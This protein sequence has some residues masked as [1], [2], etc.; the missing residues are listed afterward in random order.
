[1]LALVASM[2]AGAQAGE[3]DEKVRR[4]TLDECLLYRGP[5]DGVWLGK[6]LV[7]LGMIGVAGSPPAYRL[8]PA[9]TEKLRLL[10]NTLDAPP[11]TPELWI[12]GLPKT[13]DAKTPLVLV[14]L[15]F[16][17]HLRK[18]TKLR[19]PGPPDEPP[20]EM[21]QPEYEI[22]S[23]EI[24]S[25]E[26]LG[27]RWRHAWEELDRAMKDV[28]AVSRTPPCEEK[29]KLLLEALERAS[30]ALGTMATTAVDPESRRAVAS[31]ERRVRVVRSYQRD[32]ERQWGGQ[33]REFAARLGL[34]PATPFP[35]ERKPCPK[36]ELLAASGSP[37]EF[38]G[39]IKRD[40]SDDVLDERLMWRGGH[41]RGFVY[42]WQVEGMAEEA[43]GNLR[44]QAA[45]ELARVKREPPHP[46]D[47]PPVPPS[48]VP[49]EAWGVVLKPAGAALLAEKMLLEGTVVEK[50]LPNAP[51]AG[52]QAGDVILSYTSVYDVAMARAF[53][54]VRRLQ[55]MARYGGKLDVLRADRLITVEMKRHERE[56]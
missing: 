40:W 54:P 55:N 47:G 11:K 7:A 48:G 41:Q 36:V 16:E 34:A 5:E 50:A 27:P 28:V 17:A 3:Q 2:A 20:L 42:V 49:M 23:A 22:V 39:K 14:S 29:R 35:P 44:R 38:L 31:I 12:W 10:V 13:S 15:G 51:D 43:F 37:A 32:I 45:E 30:L 26:F 52:L 4:K 9:L 18:S 1:M 21:S 24:A 56:P 19:F 53:P 25:V 46:A 6:P 8:S 33:L